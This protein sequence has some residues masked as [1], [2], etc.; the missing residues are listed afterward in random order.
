M[1]LDMN[2]QDVMTRI[3][4]IAALSPGFL[5]QDPYRSDLFNLCRQSH[6][7][8]LH[9]VGSS[10]RLTGDAMRSYLRDFMPADTLERFLTTWDAWLYAMTRLQG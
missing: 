6:D 5:G 3:T 4:S 10:P 9:G 8:G 7:R 2:P 1:S